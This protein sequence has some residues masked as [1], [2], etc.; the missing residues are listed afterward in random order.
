MTTGY[1][2]FLGVALL[3]TMISGHERT[4]VSAERDLAGDGVAPVDRGTRTSEGGMP[5]AVDSGFLIVDNRYIPPPYRIEH[6]GEHL[7]INGVAVELPA[8]AARFPGRG[9]FG[10]GPGF[11][12]RHSFGR[13]SPWL[14]REDAARAVLAQAERLFL[15]GS[16][17]IRFTDG[18]IGVFPHGEA[19]LHS[20]VSD[21]DRTER[22]RILMSESRQSITLAQW[23]ELVDAFEPDDGLRRRLA[24]IREART[25]HSQPVHQPPEY[26][27][28]LLTVVGMMLTVA[29]F[30]IVLSHRPQHFCRWSEVN[31]IPS[32]V[33][34]VIGCAVMVG[35]LCVFDLVCTLTAARTMHFWEINPFGAPLVAQPV[36]LTVVKLLGTLACVGVLWSLRFYRGAQLASWWLCLGLTLLAAR[37]V[38]FNSLL[39]A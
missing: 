12:G 18:T 20:L 23:T 2:R 17:V 7:R 25:A 22:L 37:W 30:G 26:G 34:L 13:R 39:L 19:V 3:A 6:D 11:R 36:A 9:D 8:S 5:P 27:L 15:H 10:A 4:A 14:R 24:A 1:I 28:Y 31:R 33:R 29:S 21:L 35:V 38:V 32:D 16:L